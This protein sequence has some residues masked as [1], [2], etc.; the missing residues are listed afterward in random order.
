MQGYR[1]TIGNDGKFYVV[2]LHD[3]SPLLVLSKLDWETDLFGRKIGKLEI[4]GDAVHYFEADASGEALN[5][6]LSFADNDG[7]DLIELNP[8]ISW[9]ER[10]YFFEEQGFRLVDIKVTFITL[11]RKSGLESVPPGMGDVSFSSNEEKDEILDLTHRSFTDNPSLKSRFNNRRYFSRLDAQKYYSAWI[12]NHLGDKGTLFAVMR[13]EGKLVGYLIYR[14]KGEYQEKPLYKGV[15]VAVAPEHR[16]EKVH[17][18]LQSFVY[19][20][21]P[22]SEVFLEV[23]TQLTNLSAI[24]NYIRPNTTLDHVDLVLYRRKGEAT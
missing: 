16:G 2:S 24:K 5:A 19:S 7:F 22:E 4:V 6:M 21:F 20:H 14:K 23:T 3:T 13:R 9:F 11:M 12:E 15:L 1:T 18:T 10:I 17:R 8:D